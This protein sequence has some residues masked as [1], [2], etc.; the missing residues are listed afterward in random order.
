MVIIMKSKVIYVDF[1]Y[2]RI[3][4]SKPYFFAINFYDKIKEDLLKR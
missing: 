1:K 3:K 2:K 4:V